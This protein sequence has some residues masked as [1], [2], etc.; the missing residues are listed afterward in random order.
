MSDPMTVSE[1]LFGLSNSKN[2]QKV[3]S[4]ITVSV[5]AKANRLAAQHEGEVIM[6]ENGLDVISF[7]C[8]IGHTFMKSTDDM[9]E[10]P[11]LTRK[12]SYCTAASSSA[13]S[14]DD[15]STS[16]QSDSSG[17]WCPKCEAFYKSCKD[18]AYSCGFRLKGK[19][20]GDDLS[21]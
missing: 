8:K 1:P 16:N 21:F 10:I 12:A 14:S 4:S 17:S 18:T 20:Y 9:S 5:R 19:L 2:I 15:E 6:P 3:K 11:D 13:T 7:R